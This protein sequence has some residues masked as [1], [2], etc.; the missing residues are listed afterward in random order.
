M[1]VKFYGGETHSE[2]ELR[3]DFEKNGLEVGRLE[4]EGRFFMR[5]EKNPL[6]GKERSGGSSRRVLVRGGRCGPLSTGLWRSTR[7]RL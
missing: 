2:E 5:P 3:A 6:D 1:L 7:A 4:R